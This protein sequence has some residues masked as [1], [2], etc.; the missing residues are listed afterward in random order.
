M[1]LSYM[2][3]AILCLNFG[4]RRFSHQLNAATITRT[5]RITEQMPLLFVE[6]A[7]SNA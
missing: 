1:I 2:I 4:E 7:K 6:L 5:Q 3:A